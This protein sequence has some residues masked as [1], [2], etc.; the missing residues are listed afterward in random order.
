MN[1]RFPDLRVV[2]KLPIALAAMGFAV[3]VA[4]PAYAEDPTAAEVVQKYIDATG[5][6]E[7]LEKINSI[8][9]HGKMEISSF[10]LTADMVVYQTKDAFLLTIALPGAGDIVQG[11]KGDLAWGPRVDGSVAKL[12]GKEKE[13]LMQNARIC[14]Q[15][16]WVKYDGEITVKGAADVEGKPAWHLEFKPKSGNPVE[17]FFDQ[18]SGLLVKASM[19][20]ATEVG[21]VATV[22]HYSDYREFAGTKMSC[23]MIQ[24]IEGQGEFK[25]VYDDV[26]V[27]GNIPESRFDPPAGIEK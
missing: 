15:L 1:S 21:D 8:E 23:Q 26:K 17:R 27:N 13:Q 2:A 12:E 24:D 4:F 10:G 22:S 6:K 20:A 5:G 18:E 3:L 16:S 19:D 25:F 7:A 11:R 9:I 14:E